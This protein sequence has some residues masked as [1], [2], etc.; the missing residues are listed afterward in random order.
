M[1]RSV[2]CGMK[3][4]GWRFRENRAA[5]ALRL[6]GSR[7]AGRVNFCRCLAAAA[8]TAALALGGFLPA[9]GAGTG[10]SG[11]GIVPEAKEDPYHVK[12]LT[13][14][15]NADSLLLV[16]GDGSAYGVAVSYYTRVGELGPGMEKAGWERV[17]ETKGVYGRN[18]VDPEKREGD[19]KTPEG[20]FG[21]IMAFGLLENPGSQLPYHLIQDGDFWVDDSDSR[22]YNQLVNTHQTAVEWKSAEDMMNM[23]PYYNYGLALDYNKEGTPGAGSA[24]FVHCTKSEQD[25]GSGG[26]VRIPQEYMRELVR[27]AD[28]RMKVVIVPEASHL[29]YEAE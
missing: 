1:T 3:P 2:F 14:A 28:E 27:C 25:T 19:G 16:V 15:K 4:A 24:I 26:C 6:L 9:Y 23:A 10:R 8:V 21:V 17:F 5:K 22:Y 13:A 11:P 20:V 7:R 12:D 29:V 18:G